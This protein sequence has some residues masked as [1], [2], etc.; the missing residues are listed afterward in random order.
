MVERTRWCFSTTIQKFRVPWSIFRLVSK[1]IFELLLN[2]ARK[3]KVDFLVEHRLHKC[4]W[5][6]NVGD[7][8][9]VLVTG[10]RYWWHLFEIMLKDR[11]CWRR[12]QSKPLLTSQNCRQNILS[13]TSV[14]YIDV[15]RKS[16]QY[17]LGN[18]KDLTLECD[19]E[20]CQKDQNR[21]SIIC[22]DQKLTQIEFFQ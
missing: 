2:L 3:C 16:S 7:D 4:W 13:P 1:W 21:R 20:L 6:I 14:T 8:F 18:Q 9:G 11:G 10:F 15:A 22:T 17:K 5:Q 19:I 12:K